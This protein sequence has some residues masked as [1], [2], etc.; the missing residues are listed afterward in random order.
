MCPSNSSQ[1]SIYPPFWVPQCQDHPLLGLKWGYLPHRTK[2]LSCLSQLQ[3]RTGSTQTPHQATNGS[4]LACIASLHC[5][6]PLT[7]PTRRPMASFQ[8]CVPCLDIQGL[9]P[10]PPEGICHPFTLARLCAS[11]GTDRHTNFA[12]V[13]SSS[14][15]SRIPPRVSRRHAQSLFTLSAFVSSFCNLLAPCARCAFG[16]TARRSARRLQNSSSTTSGIHAT[17]MTTESP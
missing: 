14:S 2:L 3:V 8:R 15:N 16:S 12:T 5:T 4:C 1:G 13:C 6:C 17:A 10:A 11:A 7:K 9:A